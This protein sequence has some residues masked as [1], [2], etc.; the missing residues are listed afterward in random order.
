M[1][2]V[3]SSCAVPS[4]SVYERYNKAKGQL[5]S[6][7]FFDEVF[8]KIIII[9]KLVKISFVSVLDMKMLDMRFKCATT[10]KAS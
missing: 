4:G 2:G 1:N 7:L 3:K 10:K 9:L 6:F 5:S 8:F